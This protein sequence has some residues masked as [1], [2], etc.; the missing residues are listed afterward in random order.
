MTASVLVALRVAAPPE[1]AFAAFTEEIA[2]WWTPHL[3]F[4]ITPRGDGRLSFEGGAG[5]RLI[6]T[7]PNG[8]VFKIGDIQAWDPPTRLV[9]TWRQATFAPEMQT[10]V[11]V[12]FEPVGEETRVTVMHAGWTT[13][14]R[15]HVARHGF[16]D[17]FTQRY[18]GDWWR[19]SLVAYSVRLAA[20]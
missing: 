6:T 8:K 17:L 14:P 15:E 12:S 7:L 2:L 19:A 4:Q 11:E 5:G 1:R 18:V 3:A 16:P 9:F 13:I 20:H 10:A